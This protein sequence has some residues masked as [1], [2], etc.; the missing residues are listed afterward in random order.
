MNQ[1]NSMIIEELKTL[2]IKYGYDEMI[3]IGDREYSWSVGSTPQNDLNAAL[4][5][6]DILGDESSNFV[7][8]SEDWYWG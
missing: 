5:K 2:A 4:Q 3:L 1:H 6:R 7:L 8:E